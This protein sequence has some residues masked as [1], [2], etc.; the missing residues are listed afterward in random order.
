MN[1]MPPAEQ[2]APSP[3]DLLRVEDVAVLLNTSKRHVYELIA[4]HELPAVRL[5]RQV[6]VARG[7]IDRMINAALV[8]P[9]QRS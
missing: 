9:T 7:V 8:T 1:N 2:Y 4:R 3:R 5:G 6:R